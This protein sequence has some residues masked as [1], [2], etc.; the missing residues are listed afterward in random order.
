MP[1]TVE[2]PKIEFIT[3]PEGKPKSVILSLEDWKRISETL[4]IMSSKELI[5]SIRRAK[6]QLRTKTR[7]LSFEE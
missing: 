2:L 6:Q 1:S 4:K 7:L 5:Q 3:T